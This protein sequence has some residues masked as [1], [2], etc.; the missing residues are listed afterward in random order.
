MCSERS[1]IQL[2]RRLK[3]ASI[4]CPKLRTVGESSGGKEVKIDVADSNAEQPL[5]FEKLHHLDMARHRY[6]RQG[7]Q[8]VHRLVSLLQAAQRDFRGDVRMHE[9]F[10]FLKQQLQFRIASG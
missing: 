4:P 10:T 6:F 9:D 7:L 5:V 8:R 2:K 3:K 1:Q